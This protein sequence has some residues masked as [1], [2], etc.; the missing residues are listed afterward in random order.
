MTSDSALP[1]LRTRRTSKPRIPPNGLEGRD[2]KPY[3]PDEGLLAAA[4]AAITLGMPLL[5]TGEPGCGK[6]D[7]AHVIANYL[8]GRREAKQGIREC[9]VRSDT[10]ARDLLYHYDALRRFSDAQH[11]GPAA[12]EEA[13]D[14]RRYVELQPL[15][16]ALVAPIRQVVLIDE[17]DKAPR[18]LPN[19]LLRELERN[20]F[21][22]PEIPS[23]SP[24]DAVTTRFEAW[25][26][27]QRPIERVMRPPSASEGAPERRP[28]IVI[29]SNVERQLPDAFLRRCVF[30]HI[31]FP[32]KER[33]S[34]I[35]RER[36]KDTATASE[37]PY[38]D[39]AVSLFMGLRAQP[40]LHKKPSTAELLDW[41]DVVGE[42]YEPADALARLATLARDL[43]PASSR[44]RTRN[45]HDLP[46]LCCLIK[47]RED[48]HALG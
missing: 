5:L 11:G 20:E 33:L 28:I 25:G 22:I 41:L 16:L 24:G 10:R 46:A 15:G 32:D 18:D 26:A 9:Y 45:W 30:Y 42:T 8:D 47:L 23:T 3:L 37:E 48:L 44:L 43:D 29:T 4:N 34:E 12:R 40:G 35:L 31:R 17:I 19:D 39:H 7:F 14:P 38:L 27:D 36:R 13:Q 6:T 21:E 1:P 2:R